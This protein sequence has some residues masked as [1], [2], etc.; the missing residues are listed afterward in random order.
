MITSC[1]DQVNYLEGLTAKAFKA[2]A[3]CLSTVKMLQQNIHA[4][5]QNFSAPSASRKIAHFVKLSA[6]R[7]GVRYNN[8]NI[9]HK[10]GILY[11]VNMR[12]KNDIVFSLSTI[13]SRRCA[14]LFL[15][16]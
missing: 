1:I 2:L 14:V 15:F 13:Q 3:K 10:P 9:F 5:I 11:E 16:V 4:L 6:R 7:L 12:K 8:K